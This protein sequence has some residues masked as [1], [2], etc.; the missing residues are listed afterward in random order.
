M[1]NLTDAERDVFKQFLDRLAE[2]MGNA[3]CNDF[4]L[5]KTPS[6]EKLAIDYA[7][8]VNKDSSDGVIEPV[9]MCVMDWILLAML[10]KKVGL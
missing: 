4:D 1:L 5:P 8:Y 3:G 2:S 7:D 9:R 10:R 6:G